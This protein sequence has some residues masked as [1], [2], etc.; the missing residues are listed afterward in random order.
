M[1]E[2]VLTYFAPPERDSQEKIRRDHSSLRAMAL[3]R[4]LLDSF[5]EP[6]MILNRHRQIV[7]A[8]DKLLALRRTGQDEIIGLRPG[9]MLDCIHSGE[10]E[11][12]CGIGT[13]AV[14]LLVERY[15]GGE[16][17]FTSTLH[18]GTQFTVRLH[19]QAVA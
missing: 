1:A 13:Y 7:H 15:L 16:V 12:G 11:A 10:M 17:M 4:Q 18:G 19:R 6:A 9:E 3:V 8:N 14:K 2:K 5:P